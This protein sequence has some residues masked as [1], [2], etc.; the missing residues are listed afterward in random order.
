MFKK[1]FEI[2]D[3]LVFKLLEQFSFAEVSIDYVSPLKSPSSVT[4]W[5]NSNFGIRIHSK[6]FDTPNMNEAGYLTFSFVSKKNE[7]NENYNLRNAFTTSNRVTILEIEIDGGRIC[8]GI[9]LSNSVGDHIT[10]AANA[11]PYSV[12]A[13][14]N[15]FDFGDFGNRSAFRNFASNFPNCG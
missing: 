7:N 13:K 3:I 6:I 9:R 8:A 15:L 4:L 2:D 11:F 5:K 10:V 14:S 1:K 12:T